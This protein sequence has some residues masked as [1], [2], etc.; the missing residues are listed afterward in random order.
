MAILC[1]VSAVQILMGLFHAG[2]SQE[3]RGGIPKAARRVEVSFHTRV[4][5]L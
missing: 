2:R 4:L 5:T 3:C 1:S